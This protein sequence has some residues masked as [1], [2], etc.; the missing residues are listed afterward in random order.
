MG[1]TDTTYWLAGAY[2]VMA[3][4]SVALT[5]RP[6]MSLFHI[7]H[8]LGF[9]A[10]GVRPMLAAS[11][12]GHTNYPTAAGILEYNYG[13][14]YQIIFVGSLSLVYITLFRVDRTRVAA[15]IKGPSIRGLCAAFCLGI[16]A[17]AVL[18]VVSRGA[19]LPSA[20]PT[21]M[22]VAVPGSKYLF[23]VAIVTLSAFLPGAAL[24]FLFKARISKPLLISMVLISLLVLSLLYVR[25]MV[26]C[27]IFVMFWALEKSG[28]LK[29]SY[30]IGGF[31][32]MFLLGNIMRP[33][34]EAI[35]LYLN[36]V[37]SQ[38]AR[39]AKE[40]AERL[41]FM[42]KVRF[43]LLYTTNNDVADSW[44]VCMAYVRENGYEHGTT[45]SAI[46]ARFGGTGMRVKSG[47][48]T[49]SDKL[50]LYHYEDDYLKYSYGF[51][52]TLPNELYINFGPVAML[53][54]MIPG[55][56][57]WAADRW[58]MRLRVVTLAALFLAYIFYA[59]GTGG[60]LA[61]NIQ[62]AVGAALIAFLVETLGRIRILRQE[63][64]DSPAP[65]TPELA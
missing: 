34:A 46:P 1:T 32:A 57:L 39:V 17:V 10:F 65:S 60:E 19:W 43:V 6:V 8:L 37:K 20:R 18:H 13:I 21:S 38:E 28:K 54:G 7:S 59:Y 55:L 25:G 42:D 30:L 44:P 45:F 35:S 2:I 4:L 52:V 9:I 63:D 3:A 29:V 41:T 33:A 49:G 22:D 11:V 53:F 26:I 27:G 31:L 16:L 47:I 51:N 62:W 15:V 61:A 50:N 56:V 36:P 58:M 14:L 12:G 40:I 64:E 48:L 23:P 5:A 24:A